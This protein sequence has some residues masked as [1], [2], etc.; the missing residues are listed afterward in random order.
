V[1]TNL[2]PLDIQKT[3]DRP[4]A[5]AGDRVRFTITVMNPNT[6][7]ANDVIVIDELPNGLALQGVT[8]I[9]GSV[10]VNQQRLTFTIGTIQPN[11]SALLT[12]STVVLSVEGPVVNVASYT[13]TIG[14]QQFS[15]NSL[16]GIGSPALPNTGTGGASPPGDDETPA[17]RPELL[18]VPLFALGAAYLAIAGIRRARWRRGQ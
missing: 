2:K 15:G 13:A 18:L 12:L 16:S 4:S 1:P 3:N 11:A 14:G 10:T 7:P 17:L 5:V 9:G 6:V 8:A